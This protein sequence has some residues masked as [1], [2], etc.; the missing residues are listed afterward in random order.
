MNA[1]RVFI[2][3]A[4]PLVY[5]VMFILAAYLIYKAGWSNISFSLSEKNLTTGQQITKHL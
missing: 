5:V 2:D 4:G 1:I 3:W